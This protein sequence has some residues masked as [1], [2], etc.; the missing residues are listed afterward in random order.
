MLILTSSAINQGAELSK[1]GGSCVAT[2]AVCVKGRE[3]ERW[4][5][6]VEMDCPYRKYISSG[7]I[8]QIS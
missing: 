3:E 2:A 8:Q 7:T 1:Y 5:V 4:A 6:E